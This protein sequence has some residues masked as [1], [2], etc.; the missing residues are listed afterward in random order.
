MSNTPINDAA[1]HKNDIVPVD[2][3]S[4]DEGPHAMYEN[5]GDNI[6]RA[7]AR[8]HASNKKQKVPR[9]QRTRTIITSNKSSRHHRRRKQDDESLPIRIPFASQVLQA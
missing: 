9:H 4:I 7:I 1:A 3:A 6:N 5:L 2:R 8:L